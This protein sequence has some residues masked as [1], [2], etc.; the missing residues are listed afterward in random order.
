MK[1]TNKGKKY[2]KLQGGESATP[3]SEKAAR[4]FMGWF[5]LRFE[6]LRDKLI[7]AHK[8]DDEVAV[9]TALMINDNIRLKGLRI[10][11]K[12]KWYYLRAYH[13]NYKAAVS[14]T[15]S[16]IELDEVTDIEAPQVDYALYESTVDG[17]RR[18]ILDYVNAKYSAVDVSLFEIYIELHPEIS[19]R[20]LA[21]MLGLPYIQTWQAIS[22]IKKDVVE[23]FGGRKDILL[24]MLN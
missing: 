14:K 1:G 8:F 18:E 21:G 22:S 15:R 24:S 17:L 5:G 19:Y 4:A 6:E 7:Y 13:T 20:R 3:E 23:T 2:I 16:F 9:D 12:F 10:T 11:G